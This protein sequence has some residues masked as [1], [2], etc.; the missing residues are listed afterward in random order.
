[1]TDYDYFKENDV[2]MGTPSDR[3]SA[4]QQIVRMDSLI[5]PPL[6]NSMITPM[7]SNAISNQGISPIDMENDKKRAKK[8]GE[9]GGIWS[10]EVCRVESADLVLRVNEKHALERLSV[11]GIYEKT[12]EIMLADDGSLRENG[13]IIARLEDKDASA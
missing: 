10:K 8:V 13:K 4:G 1:M 6:M 3:F 2:V 11:T 12:G 5:S 9:F 7:N